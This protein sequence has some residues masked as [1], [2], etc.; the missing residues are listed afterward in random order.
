L[1]LPGGGY[2]F[3]SEKLDGLDIAR[4]FSERGIAA[5]VLDYRVEP[6]RH[7]VPLRDAERALRW[8]R[9]HAAE[10]TSTR[11]VWV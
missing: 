11:T 5:F 10:H 3:R 6:H 4:W 9:A 8:L 2:S 1:L 7:P